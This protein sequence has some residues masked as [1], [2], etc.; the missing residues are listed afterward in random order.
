V[1]VRRAFRHWVPA[2]AGTTTSEDESY[3]LC[4]LSQAL[5][6]SCLGTPPRGSEVVIQLAQC[7]RRT[8]TSP[9]PSF[10]RRGSFHSSLCFQA[11]PLLAKEGDRG[12]FKTGRRAIRFPHNLSASWS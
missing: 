4:S 7:V 8:D 3:D 6:G 5:A 2:F 12:R 11:F 9:N 1:I 10:E